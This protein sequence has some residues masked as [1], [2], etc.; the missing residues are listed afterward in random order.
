MSPLKILFMGSP[1]MA[2]PSLKALLES[3]DQVIGVV[4]Q[5]DKPAGRGM[6][7]V[8]PPV[9]VLAKEKKIPL[10]QPGTIK[11]NADFLKSLSELSPDVI[12]I[13]AYG[14]ILPKEI[15]DLPP[16]R[17]I[18]VHFSLLPQYRGAAPVQWALINDESETGVTTFY[19]VEKVDAGPILRQKRVLIEP[20]DNA[21]ILGHRLAVAGAGLLMETLEALKSNDLEPTPQNERLATFAP[22]LKKEDGR[23]DW[24]RKAKTV[25]SQ[26]R[27]MTPWPG[28]YTTLNG[29]MLKIHS[30]ELIAGKKSGTPG[31]VIQI[32]PL[33]IEV[34]CSQGA[35][36]LREIQLEGKRKM[37]VSEFLRGHPIEVGQKL[38]NS[39]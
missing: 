2:V 9:A 12:V 24:T 25:L 26:I 13:V 10:L 37:E 3:E 11:N 4:S 34:A 38:G 7:L 36:L 21:E 30:T 35:L 18:N 6:S 20:E 33:G 1:E 22:P 14:K 17:C 19:L 31:E 15:L 29:K 32:G 28:A 23:I 8:S 16:K 5:P 39:S 27:G